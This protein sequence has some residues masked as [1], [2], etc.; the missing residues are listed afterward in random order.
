MVGWTWVWVNSRSWWWTGRPGMLQSMGLQRDKHNWATELNY[1]FYW[2][3]R[4]LACY[5]FPD[6]SA[7]KECAFSAG[8]S[9]SIPG[10][11]RSPEKGN[12]YPLQ[13]IFLT[14]EGRNRLPTPV[15]LGFTYGLAGKE[16][17]FIE[18][19][20]SSIPGLGRSPEKGNGYPLQYSGHGLYSPWGCRV[21]HNWTTFTFTLHIKEIQKDFLQLVS[22]FVYD[23]LAILNQLAM[24]YFVFL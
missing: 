23:I 10:S 6:I 17:T 15:F 24:F 5:G 7:G 20:L 18:G 2:F 22:F 9:S 21:G 16:S 13:W 8:E 3:G 19:D 14:Q 11:G 12:G 4:D 1:W